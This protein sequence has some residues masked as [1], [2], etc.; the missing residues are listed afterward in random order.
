MWNSFYLAYDEYHILKKLYPWK[1]PS[2]IIICNI[3]YIKR[4]LS[5]NL[6]SFAKAKQRISIY[7]R[8]IYRINTYG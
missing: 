1:Y 4:F 2:L 6:S 7:T 8:H 3:R 5:I